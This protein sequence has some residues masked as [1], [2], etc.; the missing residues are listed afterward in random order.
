MSANVIYRALDYIRYLE[1]AAQE[2]RIDCAK[3]FQTREI[4]VN[5]NFP[6]NWT[7]KLTVN[8]PPPYLEHTHSVLG[9]ILTFNFSNIHKLHVF[10]SGIYSKITW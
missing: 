10:Y 7:Q 8:L 3:C 5:L 6:S 2:F 4:V 9:E 1:G